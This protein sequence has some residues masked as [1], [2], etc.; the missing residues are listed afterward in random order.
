MQIS[1]CGTF[2]GKNQQN[3]DGFTLIELSIV[4]GIAALILALEMPAITRF[5][6]RA[7]DPYN[8]LRVWWELVCERAL[9]RSEAFF[10][11]LDPREGQ[12][13]LVRPQVY[14]DGTIEWGE[15]R[16]PFLPT[17]IQLPRGIRVL[18]LV[19][20]GGEKISDLRT[21]LKVL[22]SGWV[23]PFTLHLEEEAQNREMTGF[24]NPFTCI[25]VWEDGYKE[26]ITE[27]R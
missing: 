7:A 26:R 22:P 12:F 24:M 1:P 21:L 17:K 25:L 8:D 23:D 14:G 27:I 16:D 2:K 19:H 5:L 9:F 6:S 3:L 15:I 13:R 18:D 11:E 10:V 20:K 4:L